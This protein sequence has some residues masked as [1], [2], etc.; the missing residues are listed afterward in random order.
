VEYLLDGRRVR[1]SDLLAAKLIDEGAKLVF[2]RKRVGRTHF[3]T[4][5][6]D[7]W[8]VLED[9]SSFRSPSKA[10]AVAASA[11]AF[12]GWHAWVVKESGRS[13]DSLRQEL[14]DSLA[15]APD[16]TAA[17]E[18]DHEAADPRRRARNRHEKLK[19]ARE[20]AATGQPLELAVH[21]LLTW[22]G[23]SRRD[24]LV[25]QQVEADLANYGLATS[26][27]FLKVAPDTSVRLISILVDPD[28][29][30]EADALSEPHVEPT[31]TTIPLE[32]VE[33]VSSEEDENERPPVGLSIGNLPPAMGPLATVTPQA[34]IEE[35]VT[36]MLLNNFS[37]IAVLSGVRGESNAISWKSIAKARNINPSATLNDATFRA[38]EARYDEELVDVLPRL[39]SEGFVLVRDETRAIKGIV[40]TTDVVVAYQNLAT[41]FILIGTLEQKLRRIIGDHFD[42]VE[43]SKLCDPAGDR[44]PLEMGD[45]TL[46]DYERVLE[47]PMMWE[48]LEWALDRSAFI[49]R[50]KTLRE[51]RNDV[52]HF[53]PDPL[54][55]DAIT[56]IRNFLSML[57][58][59]GVT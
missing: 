5:R 37:Q 6:E 42:M 27:N 18:A 33:A 39:E 21:D 47:N 9:G 16:Q 50:L 41:P 20:L 12:D 23:A 10:A 57:E 46:G 2:E 48:K 7:G 40:T 51:I 13:L 24:S 34:R 45:L 54:P 31:F 15:A 8:L 32:A 36:L 11:Q 28:A 35:A 49:S 30:G 14:L 4:V 17:G 56:N 1:V 25:G 44:A 59:Y 38:A 53:N 58:S 29:D 52:M 55:S 3:A 26:P 19:Q 43:I 22:W